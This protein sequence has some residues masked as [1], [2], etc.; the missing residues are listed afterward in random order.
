MR[1]QTIAQAASIAP[2]D[3]QVCQKYGEYLSATL[4]TRKEGLSWLEKARR[5]QSGSRHEL[6]SKSARHSSTSPTSESAATS[7]E[8]ALK[9]RLPTMERLHFIARN[10]GQSLGEWEQ[11]R[12]LTLTP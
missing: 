11:A 10:L 6:I 9:S 3:A 4:E 5:L 7:F 2:D 12:D 1:A 8:T